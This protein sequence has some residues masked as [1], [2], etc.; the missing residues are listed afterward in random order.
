MAAM[1]LA[2]SINMGTSFLRDLQAFSGQ[3]SA[4]SPELKT[5]C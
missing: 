4:I 5:E 2:I 1:M 3:L